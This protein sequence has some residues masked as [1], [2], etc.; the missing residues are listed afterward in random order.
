VLGTQLAD[1]QQKS[2]LG[3]GDG[4]RTHGPLLGKNAG[5]GVLATP[6]SSVIPP[7]G[8]TYQLT[9]MLG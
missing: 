4:D 2:Y 1:S 9:M 6:K 8:I 5:C 7:S 3:A